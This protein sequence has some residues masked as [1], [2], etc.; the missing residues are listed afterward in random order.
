[1][2]KPKIPNLFALNVEERNAYLAS[3]D[4]QTVLSRLIE[5]ITDDNGVISAFQSAIG[6]S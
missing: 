5:D 4:G 1:M 6:E 3:L 2:D